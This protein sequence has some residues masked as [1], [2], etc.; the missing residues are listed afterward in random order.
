MEPHHQISDD[1]YKL[2]LFER[3]RNGYIQFSQF[4]S[5]GLQ[6][7]KADGRVRVGDSAFMAIKPVNDIQRPLQKGAK[8][9][10]GVWKRFGQPAADLAV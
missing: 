2:A 5:E 7:E 8:L 10:P 3:L 9:K 4:L 6:P 1:G